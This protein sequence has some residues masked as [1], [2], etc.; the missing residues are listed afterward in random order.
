MNPGRPSGPLATSDA[1]KPAI[2]S[3][4]PTVQGRAPVDGTEV[5]GQGWYKKV[6]LSRTS[7]FSQYP[8]PT[9]YIDVAKAACVTEGFFPEDMS[10]WSADDQSSADVCRRQV[11]ACDIYLGIF[12]FNY[13]TPVRGEAEHSY[14]EMELAEARD[15]GIPVF[16]FML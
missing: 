1:P 3:I 2:G 5:P 7:E 15:R 9:S 14:T 13:G 11:G 16:V 10:R 6:F 12:G 8:M 4:I